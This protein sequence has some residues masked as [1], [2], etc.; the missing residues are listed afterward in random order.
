MQS[1]TPPL[2]PDDE[3]SWK[4]PRF[5]IWMFAIGAIIY[6]S[7][8]YANVAILGSFFGYFIYYVLATLWYKFAFKYSFA[9]DPDGGTD[10][11]TDE[12]KN[13]IKFGIMSFI[14]FLLTIS[15]FVA[16]LWAIRNMMG[17]FVIIA[18]LIA[19]IGAVIYGYYVK[20]QIKNS[21]EPDKLFKLYK[22]TISALFNFD[23]AAL[24]L[25]FPIN[26]IYTK[27]I[28]TNNAYD[29][30]VNN[31]KNQTV[32]DNE[33]PSPLGEQIVYGSALSILMLTLVSYW[34]KFRTTVQLDNPINI[35]PTDSSSWWSLKNI[36]PLD[37]LKAFPL[38]EY[39]KYVLN[40]DPMELAKKVSI[41]G[42]LAYAV[43]LIYGV[44]I[45]KKP[46]IPCT[47]SSFSSCFKTPFPITNDISFVNLLFWTLI[48]CSVV[49]LANWIIGFAAANI[50]P[51]MLPTGSSSPNMMTQMITLFKLLLF[52]F[53]WLITMFVEH[54]IA[55]IGGFMAFAALGLLLYR[56]SFDIN[57]FMAS[58]KGTVATLFIL[59]IASLVIFGIYYMNSS[60][61]DMVEGTTSYGQFIGKTGMGIAVIVC[62]VG[63]I[64][65]FL[66]SH[67]KLITIASLVQYGITALTY[68]T[69]I[70]IVVALVRT[71]F[72]TS[73]KM[74]GS[75]FQVSRD[76]DSNWVINV[77]KL[78]ANFLFYLPCLIL[79]FVDMAKEQYKLTTPNMLILLAAQAAFILIGRFLPSLVA[80]VVNHTGVQILSAPISMTTSVPITTYDVQ[81]VNAQGVSFI[82]TSSGSTMVPLKNYNYGV[83]A[84]FY[85]HPQP[86]NMN[87]NYSDGY[88]NMLRFGEFG[89]S[90]QF[91]PNTNTIQFMLYGK[92]IE[93]NKNE[94]L[95]VSDVP[96][97]TW[98]NIVINSDKGM[99]DIFINNK[100]VYTG[101]NVP[102][103]KT[104]A[105]AAIFN[106]ELGQADGVHGEICNVVLNTEAFT[107]PEIMWLYKTNRTLNPPVVGV[108]MDDQNQGQSAS[109][110]A[111]EAVDKN[112]PTPTQMPSISTSGAKTYGALGAV[113][114][115]IFG[116]L[117]NDET[118]ME[119][120][121]GLVMGAIVFGLIGALLGGLFSTDGT[122]AYVLT[123]VA[124]VF[125]DTF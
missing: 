26:L 93:L 80:K 98:N 117:F 86:P 115:A 77:L 11:D 66:N 104:N 4:N 74:G 105:S 69:G 101:N 106:V 91:S 76:P 47:D 53:Y 8:T 75:I 17:V 38:F 2:P 73:R 57:D 122:V 16:S 64:M 87:A 33:I 30:K 67:S 45:Q 72:S 96:L 50:A 118:I 84:W 97:Q 31:A 116:W 70:A 124:N 5:L 52:P 108:N 43:Y 107:K 54:P 22:S 60:T 99:V 114:G 6:N 56:S 40:N 85:I 82:P 13:N 95:T 34:W 68:I 10:P 39:A 35:D 29:D 119:S 111:D 41:F 65:Y 51:Q 92:P 110:L 112:A 25:L 7:I 9:F 123:T 37:F 61:A 23:Y 79:D 42:L 102:D 3:P 83:S 121:K 15:I 19:F 18:I 1:A 24:S 113:L 32:N 59:F 44:Y 62:L 71:L 78:M 48:L 14:N 89:P 81:F 27:V 90:V 20:T 120:I 88:I 36:F 103:D 46:L 12:G 28:D 49:N 109:F 58:Q 63:V 125:V 100:L 94:T 55:S 21:A